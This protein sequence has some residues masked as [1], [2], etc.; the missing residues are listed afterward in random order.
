MN[1]PIFTWRE[2]I[3]AICAGVL[4]GVLLGMVMGGMR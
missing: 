1:D 4:V 2:F 3:G